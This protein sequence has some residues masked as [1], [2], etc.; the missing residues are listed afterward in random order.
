MFN[1]KAP[2][3]FKI[4]L[5]IIE[6]IKKGDYHKNDLLPS[7]TELQHFYNVS[8]ITVRRAVEELQ[9]DG[10]VVKQ[11]GLGTII[12]NDKM[13]LNLKGINSFSS[14]NINE[15]SKLVS[16]EVVN[17]P[18]NVK[19]ALGLGDNCN[20]YKIER[21]R[22]SNDIII[23]FHRAFIPTSLIDLTKEDFQTIHNSLYRMLE[24]NGIKPTHGS[25]TIES[26]P[27]DEYLSEILEIEIASPLLFK[28]R[29]SLSDEKLVE[30]VEMYYI[31]SV[32]KYQVELHNM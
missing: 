7:E 1:T 23:G 15:S 29:L 6:K 9:K 20:V 32:Y 11:P 22:K 21:I 2:L 10:Y 27:A 19:L 16:F 3:Y 5:D 25:E 4:Y 14:E 24:M 26:I 8:R 31:G 30:F 12:I 17:A 13:I 28:E 18:L